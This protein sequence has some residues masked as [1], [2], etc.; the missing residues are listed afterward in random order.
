MNQD[1][2]KKRYRPNFASIPHLSE[3]RVACDEDEK[4]SLQ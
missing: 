4:Y 3:E 2:K 1:A